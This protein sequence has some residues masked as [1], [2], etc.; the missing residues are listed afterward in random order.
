MSHAYRY[1]YY[2]AGSIMRPPSA[3]IDPL[4]LIVSQS[5]KNREAAVARVDLDYRVLPSRYLWEREAEV[6]QKYGD[7]INWNWHS[8][9]SGCLMTS[10]DPDMPI[11]KF[12]EVEG[13]MTANE[14]IAYN[15]KRIAEERGGPPTMPPGVRGL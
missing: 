9:E 6:K 4:G 8:A 10:N 5:L 15:R 11:G 2:I 12:I 1:Q 7:A 13:M 3:I 14:W